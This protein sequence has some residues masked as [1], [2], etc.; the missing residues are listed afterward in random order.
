MNE[1]PPRKLT[2]LFRNS[3]Y[4]LIFAAILI[5]PA[6]VCQTVKPLVPLASWETMS[7][8]VY[9]TLL[10]YAKPHET[11]PSR[12]MVVEVDQ[13][14]IDEYGWP[15]DRTYYIDFLE[16]LKA[17]GQPW[18]LSML[19]FQ[20]LKKP[21]DKLLAEAIGS[22]GRFIGT[23]IDIQKGKTLDADQ[24]DK[25]LPRVLLSASGK[26]PDVDSFGYQL[27]LRFV[28]DDMFVKQQRAFGFGLRVGIEP[29]VRCADLYFNNKDKA[30]EFVL[31]SSLV[32]AAA[33]A[34]EAQFQTAA[35]A[36]WPRDGEP[37]PFAFRNKMRLTARE[38][39]S[40]PGM[41]TADFASQRELKS[42][43]LFSFLENHKPDDYSGKIIV[44]AGA[45]MHRYRG[46]GAPTRD[47]DDGTANEHLLAARFLDD[48]MTGSIIRRDRLADT[49]LMDWLPLIAA[50]GLSLASLFLSTT[51]V[52]GLSGAV[53]AGFLAFSAVQLGS[54]H[55]VIPMQT[56][57][58]VATT[59]VLM[60]ILYAYL[61]YYGIRREIR[62]AGNLRQALS[63][64]NTLGEIE[65]LT[66]K[67]CK[68]EFSGAQLSFGDFDRELFDATTDASAALAFLDRQKK[69][70]G[71][72]PVENEG[73][74]GGR[75]STMFTRADK[76]AGIARMP[77]RSRGMT[78]QLA[79]ESKLG[80]L[81][82][83]K[84]SLAYKPHEEG[85]VSNLLEALRIEVAQHWQRIKILVDQKLLDYRYLREHARNDIM[86][87]FLTKV[88]VDRFS[89][90]QT[91]EQNLTNVLTPR[92]TRCALMQA[93]IRGYSKLSAKLKPEEMVRLLQGYFRGVVDAAQLVAQVKL[94]GDCIFLFIEE[95][96][97]NQECSPAD[98]A[99][100]LASILVSETQ[101]QNT[102]RTQDGLGPL[103][104]GIAIHYG[105]VVVGNLS[106]DSCIDYTVIGPNVNLVARLEELTKNPKISDIIGPNGLIMSPEAAAALIKHKGQD[107]TD[108]VLDDLGVAV[109]SFA[110][111][112]RVRGLTAAKTTAIVPDA[113]QPG[114]R[115]KRVS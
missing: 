46:P 97:G 16:R 101:R 20:E 80:R 65:R 81:G 14:T 89:D 55:Y 56:L 26:A 92:P 58:S 114:L 30:G 37:Q 86:A 51:G 61:R 4:R 102:L 40:S 15:I 36:N 112:V 96:A 3:W 53:L 11:D 38:C 79:V 107:F 24:E 100:E 57:T 1:K 33:Y 62:F 113:V 25:I 72:A 47:G 32:W 108:L 13:A 76:P 5:V 52:I 77:L 98:L 21:E 74:F 59:M 49:P 115:H 67:I 39:L 6:A 2:Q 75:L 106:S 111:V 105:E 10:S 82:T 99:L 95:G 69:N 66:A 29:I 28:E 50:L 12:V 17:S 68:A 103:N 45:D 34:N 22:Y 71:S 23:G 73:A 83:I 110:E 90:D 78:V 31:P 109:R 41:T 35:G 64:C 87:R 93:D 70:L 85:F 60:S 9:A 44:L 18:V 19:R 43:S 94:I 7:E 104:F 42:V 91:M 63:Q 8:D 54:G 84:L 48:L 27:P 88:L